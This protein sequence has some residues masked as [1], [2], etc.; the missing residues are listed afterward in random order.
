LNSASHPGALPPT[1]IAN[2]TG[3]TFTF[4]PG[5][6]ASGAE[7]QIAGIETYAADPAGLD[8]YLWGLGVGV[9]AV[10]TSIQSDGKNPMQ[11]LS[12]MSGALAGLGPLSARF[13]NLSLYVV[14]GYPSVITVTTD[15]GAPDNYFLAYAEGGSGAP[16][17][18]LNSTVEPTGGNA[19]IVSVASSDPADY[20]IHVAASGQFLLTLHQNFDSNWA[21]CYGGICHPSQW[22]VN[23]YANGWIVNETGSLDLKLVFQPQR[24]LVTL[25]EGSF[26]VGAVMAALAVPR[27]RVSLVTGIRRVRKRLHRS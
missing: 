3:F 6:N 17:F 24:L 13:G 14:P 5:L 26:V 10:D 9:V 1:S 20:D 22:T 27:V 18:I 21:L 12:L 16:D 11:N 2:A 23:G 25:I 15:W 4:Q 8:Y 19:T 7:V